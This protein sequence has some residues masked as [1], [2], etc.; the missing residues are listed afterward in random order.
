MTTKGAG[1]GLSL[2]RRYLVLS[3]DEKRGVGECLRRYYEGPPNVELV[4]TCADQCRL[5]RGRDHEVWL[6]AS[7]ELEAA[8]D[9]AERRLRY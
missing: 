1:L 9:Q 4:L 2:L 7:A 5:A 8:I 3:E 6:K